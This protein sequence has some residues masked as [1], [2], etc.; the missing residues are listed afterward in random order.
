[1]SGQNTRIMGI[2]AV[3]VLIA[4]FLVYAVGF[5]HADSVALVQNFKGTAIITATS[6]GYNVSNI[7]IINPFQFTL[8]GSFFNLHTTYINYNSTGLYV[9]GSIKAIYINAPLLVRQT[10]SFNYY[11]KLVNV[12]YYT[13]NQSVDILFY[14]V[15]RLP[16]PMV[17]GTY[18]QSANVP[19]QISIPGSGSTLTLLS[20]V[21][22]SVKVEIINETKDVTPPEGYMALLALNVSISS[23]YN[24]SMLMAMPYPCSLLIRRI[25]PFKLEPNGTW[26]QIISPNFNVS[27]C[28]VS[29][30]IPKDPIVGIFYKNTSTTPSS[31]STAPT[32][33]TSAGPGGT[34]ASPQ[35]PPILD[36]I[37]LIVIAAI[38]LF[39]IVYYEK[40]KG[41]KKNTKVAAA[42]A[43]QQQ[44]QPASNEQH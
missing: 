32:T 15:P 5:A 34:A 44:T 41:K 43:K 1:M 17:N 37:I 13:K 14:S 40:T 11:A 29:F 28:T 25:L 39:V 22:E 16:P 9:N 36:I 8:N 3:S 33:T 24:G 7:T 2:A 35:V 6:N 19:L 12:S 42:P 4:L 38:A 10:E 21:P 18:G 26:V 31:A 27:A 23:G 30:S 20:N